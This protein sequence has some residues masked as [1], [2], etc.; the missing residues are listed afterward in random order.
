ME[1]WHLDWTAIHDLVSRVVEAQ[2]EY[3]HSLKEL[4]KF[5]AIASKTAID[6]QVEERLDDLLRQ[7]ADIRLM[8]D[9]LSTAIAKQECQSNRISDLERE[10]KALSYALGILLKDSDSTTGDSTDD[11]PSAQLNKGSISLLEALAFESSKS[12]RPPLSSVKQQIVNHVSAKKELFYPAQIAR[13]LGLCSS[14]VSKVLQELE[15]G[16][17]IKSVD[18]KGYRGRKLYQVTISVATPLCSK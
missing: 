6:Q 8:T 15:D 12:G 18:N 2:R 14:Y 11:P 1:E 13:E 7:V 4:E 17:C 3:R 5:N 9:G 10:I 16:R